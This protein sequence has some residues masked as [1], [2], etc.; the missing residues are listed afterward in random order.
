MIKI[1]VIP[2]LLA[3]SLLY[4]TLPVRASD[5]GG[6]SATS[7]PVANSSGQAT[8]NAYQVLNG[9]YMNSTFTGGVNCQSSTLTITPYAGATF[10]Q[11]LPFEETYQEPVYDLRDLDGDT[12]PDNP[13]DILFEKTIQTL[14]KDNLNVTAGFT[15]SWSKSLDKKMVDLCRTAA[16]NQIALQQ[17][18]LNMKVLDYEMSRLKHCGNLAKEGIVWASNSKYAAICADV[19]VINP[20]GVL[21]DHSHSIEVEKTEIKEIISSTPVETIGVH[22]R[23]APW[24]SS[25]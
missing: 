14:Q 21:P 15:A 19:N 6:I 25:P 10:G 24:A 9:T 16:T 18:S 23:R 1:P 4:T 22:E 17:A 13:G 5:I 8:V 11:R 3:L 2:R 20:P 12:V 7:N